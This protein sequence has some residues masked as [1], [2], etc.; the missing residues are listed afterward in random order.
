M[1]IKIW[2]IF[3][4]INYV[5]FT[6]LVLFGTI[7]LITLVYLASTSTENKTKEMALYTYIKDD[8]IAINHAKKESYYTSPSA[9]NYVWYNNHLF[10]IVKLADDEVTL[11]F[12]DALTSITW[13]DKIDYQESNVD[14][15]VN[16]EVFY[17]TFTD[18]TCLNSNYQ[19]ELLT[20]EDY[21]KSGSQNSFINNKTH[22]FISPTS[23]K[24]QYIND[25]G[26]LGNLVD[27]ETGLGVRP[28][29]KV[30]SKCL[31]KSGDGTI[32]NPYQIGEKTILNNKNINQASVGSYVNFDNHLWR[33][34][35]NDN[36][37]KLVSDS[38]LKQTSIFGK[39]NDYAN[40]E[41]YALIKNNYPNALPI[42]YYL[43]EYGN[44]NNYNYQFQKHST[45][46]NVS[47]L[48][49]GDIFAN[50]QNKSYFLTTKG[51]NNTILT[52]E[53]NGVLFM[54]SISSNLAIRPVIMIDKNKIIKSGDGTKIN[55]LTIK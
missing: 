3:K 20:L 46:V 45:P 38:L 8:L 17:N 13:G 52:I 54:N 5:I 4:I 35:N 36:D 28:V 44:N 43:D 49:V 25:A 51:D 21:Q 42:S 26:E 14:R 11:I 7:K 29:V 40:S 34:S 22:F 41:V 12:N 31:V 6:G 18:T 27:H 37:V 33:I 55:P 10:R 1:K 19:F 30:K 2:N 9:R 50:N 15:W 32:N 47:L 48:S 53:P 16:H 23:D 39:S 24:I